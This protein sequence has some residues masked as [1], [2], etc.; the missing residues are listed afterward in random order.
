[1]TNNY[2]G[3][4]CNI[5]QDENVDSLFLVREKSPIV[6]KTGNPYLRGVGH[7][8]RPTPPCLPDTTTLHYAEIM[9]LV[10]TVF[11]MN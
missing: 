11:I 10:P 6:T 8:Q 1:M 7:R 5:N 3:T 4:R 9:Y 2:Y